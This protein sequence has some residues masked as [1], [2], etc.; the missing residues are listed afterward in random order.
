MRELVHGFKPGSKT[1]IVHG[2]FGPS[3]T[4]TRF[5]SKRI[6]SLISETMVVANAVSGDFRGIVTM[7]SDG[8]D[9]RGDLIQ[10]LMKHLH[11]L[12][13]SPAGLVNGSPGEVPVPELIGKLIAAMKPDESVMFPGNSLSPISASRPLISGPEDHHRL[14]ELYEEEKQVLDLALGFAPVVIASASNFRK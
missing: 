14:T 12:V 13:L 10:D 11:V 8:L 7:N 9:I 3:L 4:D 1:L 5:V 6:S 2:H